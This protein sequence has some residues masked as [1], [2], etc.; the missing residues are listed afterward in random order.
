MIR[1]DFL[2]RVSGHTFARLPVRTGE[3]VAVVLTS[4]PDGAARARHPAILRD[5]PFARVEVLPTLARE[6]IDQVPADL[7]EARP[8]RGGLDRW[9]PLLPPLAAP[10]LGEGGTPLVEL[11][12]GVFVKDESRNP[13]WSHKDRLNRCTV[14]AA[15]AAG[16]PVSSSPPPATTGPPPPP[17][18]PGPDSGAWC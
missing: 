14:S 1:R 3:N 7:F 10:G 8:G 11:E 12:P 17:S 4:H 13:T 9:A 2:V 6:R 18:P 15:L 5:H 16:R